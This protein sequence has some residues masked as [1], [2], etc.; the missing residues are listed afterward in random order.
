MREGRQSFRGAS[1]RS[2]RHLCCRTHSPTL[3][4]PSPVALLKITFLRHPDTPTFVFCTAARKFFVCHTQCS[5]GKETAKKAR[6]Q[7][8]FES[9]ENYIRALEAKVKDLQSN[10]D[11][12]RQNHGGLSPAVSS[13]SH[14][15]DEGANTSQSPEARRTV[16]NTSSTDGE[17]SSSTSESDIDHLISPTRH[18]VVSTSLSASVSPPFA[19]R[20]PLSFPR[21]LLLH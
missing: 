12:C 9:L 10:L 3:R 6:T 17:G 14:G 1:C 7:Q 19:V 18:L 11:S 15:A 21:S 5:W 8:H 2:R 4:H 13:S 20:S 16:S